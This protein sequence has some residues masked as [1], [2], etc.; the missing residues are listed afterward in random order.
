MK[1]EDEKEVEDVPVLCTVVD[2]MLFMYT[3]MY[4]SIDILFI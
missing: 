2:N 1:E 3:N 4:I